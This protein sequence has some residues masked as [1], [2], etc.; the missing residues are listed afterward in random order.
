MVKDI[1]LKKEDVFDSA[2]TILRF[3]KDYNEDNEEHR[4]IRKGLFEDL[5]GKTKELNEI[6]RLLL[7]APGLISI[8][9]E[10]FGEMLKNENFEIHNIYFL[11]DKLKEHRN[12]GIITA[13]KKELECV[14]LALNLPKNSPPDRDSGNF[15]YWFSKIERE[16]KESLSVVAT[17]INQ[18]RNVP[19]VIAVE[20]LLNH[21]T[22][23]LMIFIGIAAGPSEKVKL[24]DFVISDRVYDYEHVRS[25]L[26]KGKIVEKPRPLYI[27][28]NNKIRNYLGTFDENNMLSLFNELIDEIPKNDLPKVDL[29]SIN[30]S[31]H[32]GTIIAGERLFA[33]GRM[34]ELRETVDERIRACD[35]E[36]SGF[37]Q[38]CE[39]R[40]IDWCIF[41]GI[42][43][44]GDPSKNKEWHS[45]ASLS[46]ASAAKVFLEQFYRLPS[47]TDF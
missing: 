9:P 32:R 45:L 38:A 21:F 26:I 44:Y 14:L 18:P 20:H 15:S 16:D 39:F 12:I 10:N 7:L 22:I 34:K 13:L 43:D 2:R 11:S 23:D 4:F 28:L 40:G 37:V 30:P 25:E 41:R 31:Y 5:C 3:I 17:I 47:E 33:D 24:G 42:S 19:A 46:A 36:D 6:K 29:K 1:R 27:E 35:Q 8:L